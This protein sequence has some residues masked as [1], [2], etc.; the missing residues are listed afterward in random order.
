MER[1]ARLADRGVKAAGRPNASASRAALHDGVA[2][3][4]GA[5]LGK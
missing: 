3:A 2:Q 5:V 4:M 1:R